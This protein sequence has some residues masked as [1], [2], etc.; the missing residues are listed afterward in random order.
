[1]FRTVFAQPHTKAAD[2]AWHEMRDR[3]AELF[4]KV[5]AADGRRQGRGCLPSPRS[6]RRTGRR[7]GQRIRSSGST[8]S[9]K[10]RSRVVGI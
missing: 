7:S 9:F 8:K 3:L 4:P 6:R 5:G 2:A 1:M 10:R